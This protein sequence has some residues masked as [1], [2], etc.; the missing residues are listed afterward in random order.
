[1]ARPDWRQALPTALPSASRWPPA[2]RIPEAE[3]LANLVAGGEEDEKGQKKEALAHGGHS[4]HNRAV[5]QSEEST[6][7]AGD[8]SSD[9]DQACSQ[10]GI[11]GRRMRR[12]VPV[13]S[14]QARS[15]NQRCSTS[16]S[17]TKSMSVKRTQRPTMA[18]IH[19]YPGEAKRCQ[20]QAA[21]PAR[22]R[23]A[24]DQGGRP[25]PGGRSRS[26]SS[27]NA[28]CSPESSDGRRQAGARW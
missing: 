16:G 28:T 19:Q 24:R 2:R 22:D 14:W 3:T 12:N 17:R 27:K 23:K 8:G 7:A 25:S 10:K 26:T 4:S 20:A 13:G 9:G 1:M 18:C 5:R 6:V 11:R 15:R 21:E